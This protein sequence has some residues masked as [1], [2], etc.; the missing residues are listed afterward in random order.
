MSVHASDSNDNAVSISEIAQ[1]SSER[2]ASNNLQGV[3]QI[4]AISQDAINGFFVDRF[5]TTIRRKKDRRLRQFTHSIP[6]WGEIKATL[7]APRVDLIC[8]GDDQSVVFYVKFDTGT[9]DFWTG[10]GPA[11]EKKSQIVDNWSIAFRTT[12][13]L[14]TLAKVPPKIVDQISLLKPGSYSASQ[15][16][17]GFSAGVAATL[18]YNLSS[19]PGQPISPADKSAAW[20]AF[21][22][23]MKQYMFYMKTGPF[24]VLGYAIKVDETSTHV[25]SFPPTKMKCKTQA[26]SAKTTAFK[27]HTASTSSNQFLYLEMCGQDFP[28]VPYEEEKAGN[29]IVGGIPASLCISKRLYWDSYLVEKLRSLNDQ[30]LNL[31]NDVYYW[32]CEPQKTD[33]AWTIDTQAKP[34]SPA[35]TITDT[36]AKYEW[37]GMRKT[38]DYSCN[39]TITTK[40]RN[41][42]TMA[43]GDHKVDV[44]VYIFT[45]HRDYT[46]GHSTADNPGMDFIAETESSV[47]W[48][49]VISLDTIVGGN[50]GVKIVAAKP[51]LTYQRGT[52][53]DFWYAKG[54]RDYE[55]QIRDTL[56]REMHLEKLET[57]LAGILNGQGTLVF[58]GSGEFTQKNP[59]FTQNG[60]LLVDLEYVSKGIAIDDD[61]YI[62]V[63]DEK[64]PYDKYF[65]KVVSTAE[66]SA[67]LLVEHQSDAT[68]FTLDDGHLFV[69]TGKDERGNDNPR[70]QCATTKSATGLVQNFLFSSRNMVR[71]RND[72]KIE[73]TTTGSSLAYCVD[74]EGRIWLDFFVLNEEQE[75]DL[76]A[77]PLTD[78]L[79]SRAFGLYAIYS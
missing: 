50:L 17:L 15:L 36:E 5:S 22:D 6:L 13:N 3:D 40:V 58:P 53:N 1:S 44:E 77:G 4:V 68:L 32:T 42:M 63:L 76:V 55:T 19:C 38:G 11:A 37:D 72:K 24:S 51:E 60:D 47:T 31:C 8:P 54:S 67:A 65:V 7:A 9:F 69:D 49:L 12:F 56:T 16:I 2:I 70:V 33:H 61:F 27:S 34:S 41:K 23:Y 74:G 45:K 46:I 10:H 52:T 21:A 79:Q 14:K 64:S 30:A 71:D 20:E 78:E 25:E 62:Q 39:T 28:A 18:D 35:W 57:D 66:D 26:Y 43:K 73:F 75:L 29:W 48:R 59:T